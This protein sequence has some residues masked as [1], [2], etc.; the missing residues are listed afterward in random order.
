MTR[1][2]ARVFISYA[3]PDE[4]QAREIHA[5]LTRAGFRPWLDKIDLA[6][7]EEWKPAIDKAIRASG[8][9]LS[10]ISRNSVDRGGVLRGEMK[11]A[12]DL[13]GERL[14]DGGLL[15]PVRLEDCPLPPELQNIQALDWFEP[16]GAD[17][18]V[19]ILNRRLKTDGSRSFTAIV[20]WAAA[21]V[22]LCGI[23]G[24][25]VYRGFSRSDSNNDAAAPLQL[26][27]SRWSTDD[28]Q[29]DAGGACSE[30]RFSAQRLSE[31]IRLSDRL[32]FDVR[33]SKPG[34]L[35]VIARELDTDGKRGAAMLLF[36]VGS[37]DNR[38]A[39]DKALLIPPASG[40]V[41]NTLKITHLGEA[42]EMQILFSSPRI[43][44]LAARD[45]PYPIG[46]ELVNR[47]ENS[48]EPYSATEREPAGAHVESVALPDSEAR[49]LGYTNSGFNQVFAF[50]SR[51]RGKDAGRYLARMT[52]RTLQ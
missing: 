23:V 21:G 38:I 17:R 45:A 3:R 9:F 10:L 36:P 28:K 2:P 24:V 1:G 16:N 43:A 41:C 22:L 35:Y 42:E 51:T 29:A 48:A 50:N 39:P 4:A 44:G 8:A 27:V 34:Y 46:E 32:R 52:L 13:R 18:L 5:A 47:I 49:E 31:P 11:L 19:G 14:D 26:T 30:L 37:F 15:A 12:L 7:G 6:P 40:G 33:T 25:I 20:R